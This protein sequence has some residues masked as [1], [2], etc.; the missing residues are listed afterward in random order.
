MTEKD[1]FMDLL[2]L[3][4]EDAQDNVVEPD[5]F[6]I[7]L[8]EELTD[9]ELHRMALTEILKTIES[10]NEV[11]SELKDMVVMGADAEFAQAFASV[12]KANSDAIKVI[13]D[14]ALQK[15]R[16]KAQK[17]LKRIDIDGKKEVNEHKH[18]LEIRDGGKKGTNTN[19]LIMNR[20]E[21]FQTLFGN[22]NN[23]SERDVT[24][25]APL[26]EVEI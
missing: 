2:S 18:D 7:K 1:D 24:P 19:V 12:T 17:E 22:S 21:V 20:E 14:I 3:A 5:S 8:S 6:Q 26:I 13:T 9:D 10:N 15:E 4:N 25:T 23:R 16:L 11:I